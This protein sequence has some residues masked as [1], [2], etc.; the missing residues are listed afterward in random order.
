MADRRLLVALSASAGAAMIAAGWLFE[1]AG[2]GSDLLLQLGSTFLLLAPVLW[3]ERLLNRSI[4]DVQDQV[5]G[6]RR[7]IGPLAETYE[8]TRQDRESGPRRTTL[9]EQVVSDAREK[10]R[11]GDHS[12]DEVARLFKN[13]TDGERVAALGMMQGAHSLV[14]VDVIVNCIAH[15]RSAFEQWHALL[16]ALDAWSTFSQDSRSRI[17]AAI[18]RQTGPGGYIRPGTDRH[19]IARGLLAL[20]RSSLSRR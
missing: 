3:I 8:R 12:A 14:N 19:G 7:Q 9:L 18:E 13:G 1:G 20:G 4:R 11:A 16:V 17:I 15:S 2:Y 10:G 5:D 6:L